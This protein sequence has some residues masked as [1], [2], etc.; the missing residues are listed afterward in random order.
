MFGNKIRMIRELRGFSQNQVAGRLGITQASYSRIETNQRKLDTETLE[1]IA[2]ELEVK[3]IDIISHE[4]AVVNFAPNNGLQGI[5]DMEIFYSFQK[6][7]VE[8][9]F[10]SKDREIAILKDI[11]TGLTE[12]KVLFAKMLKLKVRSENAISE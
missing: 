10:A 9:V 6:D 7:L 11:I 1:K 2:K 4:P 12:D 5:R 3:P 8:K